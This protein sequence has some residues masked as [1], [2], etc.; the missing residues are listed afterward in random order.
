MRLLSQLRRRFENVLSEASSKSGNRKHLSVT[1][2]TL[3]VSTFLTK[4]ADTLVSPKITLTALLQSQGASVQ[5]ISLLVPLRESGALLPQLW[6]ADLV[7]RFRR[8]GPLYSVGT[9][10]Q[11]FAAMFMMLSAW[12]LDGVAAGWTIV[13]CL[14]VLSIARALCSI[15]FKA[16]LGKTVP[17][18]LRGQTT[19]WASSAA[20]L[21]TVFISLVLLI[22]PERSGASVLILFLG[23]GSVCWW[24]ASAFFLR[25]EE[26]A[27]DRVDRENSTGILKRLVLLR[28]QKS[29]RRFVVVRS[30]L[31]STALVAPWYVMLSVSSNAA[32][33]SVGA[34]LL[35]S[36]L[37]SF[38]SSPLWGRYSD[39]S[40]RWVLQVCAACISAL[41]VFTVILH[42]VVPSV[43]QYLL[44]VPVLYFVLEV[45][46]QG[47]RIARKTYVVD[48]ANDDNR[49]DYIAI[50]NTLIG[51]VIV[52]VGLGTGIVAIWLSPIGMIAMF[53][54]TAALGALLASTLPE[55]L[56]KS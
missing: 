49:V 13:V 12:L 41:G 9:L 34:L 56:E 51:I 3:V 30:L 36:G 39:R 23:L 52:I 2:A 40:S 29:F 45:A 24:L 20:G 50:S 31:V 47:V 42:F 19:G 6:L 21:A 16:V 27:A 48:L 26:E 8:L 54:A 4:T 53:S 37:A 43:F 46:H 15:S 32:L 7:L 10:I 18:G 1:V 11:G 25:V 38:V 5:A 55:A 33:G 44:V 17:A 35:A 14:S 22:S 28:D